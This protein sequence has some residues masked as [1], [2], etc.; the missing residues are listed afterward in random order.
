MKNYFLIFFFSI[1]VNA[2]LILEIT[3]GSDNPY[4][5]AIVNS[6]DSSIEK[7]VIN[8]VENDL[9]RTGE[10]KIF[11]NTDLIQIPAYEDDI[12]FKDFSI[13]GID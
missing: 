6:S 7:E 3:K 1:S 11:R 2:E 10:F 9:L 8:I 12:N 4:K 13:L 5:I